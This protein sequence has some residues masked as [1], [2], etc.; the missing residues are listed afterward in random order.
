MHVFM[1]KWG[2]HGDRAVTVDDLVNV[3]VV[4]P[5]PGGG[6]VPG[7]GIGGEV[8]PDL[9]PPPTPTGFGVTAS[10]FHVMVSHDTPTYTQGRGHLRTRVYGA[11]RVGAAPAPVFADAVEIDQFTGVFRAIPSNPATTWHLWIR[12][13]TRDGVVSPLPAGGTNGLVAVTAQDVS[14]LLEALAGEIRA[15]EL[16]SSLSTPIGQIPG[17][18]STASAALA[19]AQANL[20]AISTMQ[21]EIADLSGTPNYDPLETYLVDRIV[22]Y[23][24]GLYRATATTTGNLP[25]NTAFWELIGNY[26][27]LGDAVS[28]HAAIL[29]DHETRITNNNGAITAQAGQITTLQAGLTTANGQI[30]LRAT[31]SAVQALD[32]R[33]TAAEGVNTTQANAITNLQSTT[34]SLN[35]GL[36]AAASATNALGTRVTATENVNTSQ[37]ASITSLNNSLTTLTGTV[38]TKADASALTALDTRVTAAEGVNTSQGSSITVL[39]NSLTTLSNTVATKADASAL[40]SLT[41]RVTNAEGTITSQGSSIT[42]LQNSLTTTNNTVATKADSTA[43]TATNTNVANLGNTLTAQ[44]GQITTLQSSVN[45]NA[46][47]IQTE[48]TTRATQTGELYA[49]YTVKTDVGGLVSGYGLASQATNGDAVTLTPGLYSVTSDRVLSFERAS[50]ATFVDASGVLQTAAVNVPRYTYFSG[51]NI[52]SGPVD[53]VAGPGVA[54]VS[55]FL[56]GSAASNP[57]A[58]GFSEVVTFSFQLFQDVASA[59]VPGR[60]ARVLVQWRSIPSGTF[61]SAL[62][63]SVAISPGARQSITL[64]MPTSAVADFDVLISLSKVGG[65]S[66]GTITAANFMAERGAVATAYEPGARLLI[67][68]AATNLL[69]PSEPTVAQVPTLSNVTNAAAQYPAF[70][71]SLLFPANGTNSFSYLSRALD[72]GQQFVFSV[73]VKIAGVP[74]F[75]GGT[76]GSADGALTFGSNVLSV[77]NVQHVGGD[78]WRIWVTGTGPGAGPNLGVVKYATNSAKQFWVMGYQLEAGATPRGYAV[79][80]TAPATRAAD[81]VT[82]MNPSVTSRFGVQAGQFFV[83]PPTVNQ[84]TAPTENLFRGYVWR[85]STTGLVQYWTGSA[86]STTPQ[87]LPFVVQT[88]PQ[89]INGFTVEPGIYGENAFFAR[90]VATRGQIGLL[91]VDDARIASMSVDKLVAGS[92]AV[93]QHI[94][95]TGYVPG[96]SGWRINGDGTAEFSQVVVRGTI[97]AGQGSIGGWTIGPNYLQSTNYAL[98]TSGTRLNSDGTG[99]IG[100]LTVGSNFVQNTGFV[101]FQNGFSLGSNGRILAYSNSGQNILDTA[102][103]GLQVLL[104]AGTG[105]DLRAN[106]EMF[107]TGRIQSPN[108]LT[109]FDPKAAGSNAV[110]RVLN[111]SFTEMVRIE[112]E[113][114]AVFND[115]VLSRP[116][117]VAQGTWNNPSG[118]MQFVFDIESGWIGPGMNVLVDTGYDVLND[119]FES[120]GPGF[121]CRARA[122]ASVFSG[123]VPGGT[124]V[125]DFHIEPAV[126]F[127]VPHFPAGAAGTPGGRIL[128][129]LQA[130]LPRNIH[131]NVG[132][133]RITQV[134]WSLLRLT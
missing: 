132:S 90:L 57:P 108:G 80:T 133:M 127:E 112:A 65:A 15:S 85:N 11:T 124:K 16:S 93:G 33:V 130:T 51:K 99:Q 47:A 46:A 60:L 32:T 68:D 17:I 4:A 70:Q 54:L 56:R 7:P 23:N 73:F 40:N 61:G 83:A 58:L 55:H 8:A 50:T 126:T 37:G 24:G 113:G 115:I 49:Q 128:V 114:R 82:I 21:S 100:G 79:S 5:A 36:A 129:R 35:D 84:A 91:A 63:D 52:Y 102:A 10:M 76:A 25:T 109:F 71:R 26:A 117:I 1:G 27:S 69:F 118:T 120:V 45:A 87:A 92:I 42:G 59:A 96:S 104:R 125:A 20:A 75:T 38:N 9:T 2:R 131:P 44:A 88:T 48:A 122:T 66:E 3:G 14:L 86:W 95:S 107:T 43:L 67:E 78:L 77:A 89:V 30:A 34:V 39:N 106:G 105:F 41:T 18:S 97:F 94:Q 12:W 121:I 62:F 110:L 119:V 22:R 123:S 6:L 13:E 53:L 98:G 81:V 29:A 31:T 101:D 103:T 116:N 134:Q 19:Q 72:A 111:S 64:T 74:V 28:G